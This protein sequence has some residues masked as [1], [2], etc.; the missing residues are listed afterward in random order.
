MQ[1]FPN[2]DFINRL[3][4][5]AR[6]V[7]SVSI[8]QDGLQPQPS[9]G[10][11]P[12]GPEIDG[13]DVSDH[14]ALLAEHAAVKGLARFDPGTDKHGLRS[15]ANTDNAEVVAN[16][17]F[18]QTST[19]LFSEHVNWSLRNGGSPDLKALRDDA[20]FV[21][22]LEDRLR[23]SHFVAGAIRQ[24][25]ANHDHTY[26]TCLLFVYDYI[27]LGPGFT[28]HLD[29]DFTSAPSGKLMYTWLQSL[30]EDVEN[31]ARA[32][33]SMTLAK[34]T[35]LVH[36]ITNEV[37]QVFQA[38][39]VVR[40]Q[41]M[42]EMGFIPKDVVGSLGDSLK[43]LQEQDTGTWKSIA[44]QNKALWDNTENIW[45]NAVSSVATRSTQST[46][47]TSN[48]GEQFGEGMLLGLT[49]GTVYHQNWRETTVTGQPV[50]DWINQGRT[51]YSSLFNSNAPNV[52]DTRDYSTNG[53]PPKSCFVAGTKVATESGS[54]A[55][56]HITEG[57]HI[58]TRADPK[59]YGVASDEDVVVPLQT[60]LLCGINGDKPFFTAGHVFHTTSGLKA[61]N[62]NAAKLENPWL[63]VG[64]LGPGHILYRLSSDGSGYDHIEVKTINRE[65]VEGGH[66]Y[67]VHLREGHRSYHADGYLVAV[68][69]PEITLKSI[70]KMLLT[71]PKH[72]QT[73]LLHHINE[74]KP[75]FAKF[76]TDT[77]SE[78]L[79]Q[80]LRGHVR[81]PASSTTVQRTR[82]RRVLTCHLRKARRTYVLHETKSQNISK[83][84]LPV[85]SIHEGTVSLNGEAQHRA[86]IDKNDRTIRWT[87]EVPEHGFEHGFV[88]VLNHGLAGNG[89]ILLS[90][91]PDSKKV[92]NNEK[93]PKLINFQV[94]KPNV[95]VEAP[96]KA[97]HH[98]NMN[99]V[100]KSVK[101]RPTP[102]AGQCVKAS[103]VS[104]ALPVTI[105][106]L[107]LAAAVPEQVDPDYVD[108]ED[109]WDL[110]L[111]QDVW[112]DKEVRTRPNNPV[113]LGQVAFAT[114]H[115]GG[116]NGLPVPILNMPLL[117][118]L[119]AEINA[120]HLPNQT[121][122]SSLYSSVVE[123]TSDGTQMGTIF[124]DS[125][126]LLY[127][128]ADKPEGSTELSSTLNLTFKNSLGSDI[129]LPI[130]FRTL[131]VQLSFNFDSA[132]GAALE[133]DASNRGGDGARHYVQDTDS[134]SWATSLAAVNTRLNI[135]RS[136]AAVRPTPVGIA[137]MASESP[138]PVTMLLT[139]ETALSTALLEGLTGYN[140]LSVHSTSQTLLQNMMLFHMNEDDR[141]T[142]LQTTAPANLP[143]E[144]GANL[145]Q[146]L[147]SWIHDTYGP[148]YVSFMVSQTKSANAK[149]RYPLTDADKDKIWYWWSGSGEK[150]LAKSSQYNKLNALT[151]VFAMRQLYSST[152]QPYLDDGGAKWA[153]L[154]LAD[155]TKSDHAKS[156]YL[157]APIGGGES[158][159]NKYCN[160]LNALDSEGTYA[161]DFFNQI[162]AFAISKNLQNPYFPLDEEAAKKQ[163]EWLND[164]MKQLILQVLN[165][166]ASLPGTVKDEL[167]KDLD[168]LAKAENL[169]LTK[170]AETRAAE[171]VAKA[172]ELTSNIV[173]YM[174]YI[175][176]GFKALARC[177]GFKAAAA[178]VNKAI[179]KLPGTGGGF[180]FLK[181]T[182]VLV[183]TAGYVFSAVS[184]FTNWDKLSGPQRATAI[185]STIAMAVDVAAKSFELFKDI[186]KWKQGEPEDLPPA[187]AS[188]A[189][190]LDEQLNEKINSPEGAAE[191]NEINEKVTDDNFTLRD[192]F[193]ESINAEEQPSHSADILDHGVDDLGP[194]EKV[195]PPEQAPE[196]P[197][198]EMPPSGRTPWK[199]FST[200][201]RFLK[202]VNIGI[203]IAFTISMSLDL[204][205]NWDKY[206]DVGKALNV[207][208][209]AIQGLTVLV[210]AAILVGDALIS[211]GLV[212]AECTMMVALPVIG[213]VL[214]VI[215]IVVMLVLSFLNVSKPTV[216]EDTPVEK[217]LKNTAH[218]LIDGLTPPPNVAL[219]Y[220]V[221]PNVTANAGSAQVPI[222]ATNNTS[223]DVTLTRST[224]TLE[225]GADDAAL[226][227]GPTTPWTMAGTY[228][229]GN[230]ST[231][232]VDGTVGVAGGSATTVATGKITQQAR[233]SGLSA[234]DLAVMGPSV[235]GTSGLLTV[236][237]GESVKIAWLGAINKA[238]ST[239]LQVIETLQNGD[240]CRF[241]AD[242]VRG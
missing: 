227:S 84:T 78:V 25:L 242:I 18:S 101:P 61:V 121:Q 4:N 48:G 15:C 22:D 23:N 177:N 225:V 12:D 135:S 190:V 118:Q 133:Y 41:A 130:L 233:G 28:P 150:C 202:C 145:Q 6:L 46:E 109:Y 201:E 19:M 70:A 214:A 16:S 123:I 73:A 55:I 92:P 231:L 7:Q 74:L 140:S 179:K 195:A 64:K 235:A 85:L 99:A 86:I 108:G 117:D 43:R 47:E 2:Q 205:D 90:D 67:G 148:A 40:V 59:T 63:E 30:F 38:D 230:P 172:A 91:N 149:W 228:D 193:M 213:A 137:A 52:T 44:T 36:V 180:P 184:S 224:L 185:I 199:K 102:V 113:S 174:D 35:S 75:L 200:G 11:D 58:L 241:L 42:T 181:G 208:Q 189:E 188:E 175:G 142:F 169:D 237:A 33:I 146:E 203:G 212:A 134:I 17:L 87:R 186:K 3:Y 32:V 171:T 80:E 156:G 97:L 165:N 56:E 34:A 147:K 167:K 131:G 239:S 206:T 132:K 31:E 223:A 79:A 215:G 210:D 110:T 194:G 89:V 112:P 221:P 65:Q 197:P 166:D 168:D 27:H 209:V 151:S 220:S 100:L 69:Y 154:L 211:A 54:I 81:R 238:G 240:K 96:S 104:S 77:I 144:L 162:V 95:N 127:Q 152:L 198:E 138:A 196:E 26:T 153:K 107:V 111:D 94:A 98:G 88:D 103:R 155:L 71:F 120:K 5:K 229:P 204:K 9:F 119:C 37:G 72:Q 236:K 163:N 182:M 105:P 60:T 93:G 192:T 139:A 45:A 13:V 187:E 83:Y 170:D 51:Q 50:A 82:K 53:S 232:S 164:A 115:S 57:T 176:Q 173:M 68:N 29:G 106:G 178:V 14:L 76:G 1:S 129:V 116:H 126:A 114:Y 143:I 122:L 125:A 21:N 141:T 218:P 226:F 191:I 39:N 10:E 160:I 217:F 183:V 136:L 222:T 128:L 234:Y 49:F 8:F 161:D 66:V 158:V 20:N 159:L 62:P 216:P 207:L 24:D 157:R 219:T 124:L